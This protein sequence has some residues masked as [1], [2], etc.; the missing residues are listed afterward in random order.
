MEVET[1]KKILNDP[2]TLVDI[3]RYLS[4]MCS[5]PIKNHPKVKVENIKKK[6]YISDL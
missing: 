5:E 3:R 1:K 2:R 4:I 6:H